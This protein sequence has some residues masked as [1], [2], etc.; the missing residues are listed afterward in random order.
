MA[1]WTWCWF[2]FN[3]NIESDGEP[4]MTGQEIYADDVVDFLNLIPDLEGAQSG[5]GKAIISDKGD[6]LLSK[7]RKNITAGDIIGLFDILS[8]RVSGGLKIENGRIGALVFSDDSILKT[9]QIL[10]QW[11]IQN[12]TFFLK[13]FVDSFTQNGD[14]GYIVIEEPSMCNL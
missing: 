13:V 8:L 12:D 1:F 6:T 14:E 11:N 10:H 9:T 4:P 5:S 3:L 7:N 2:R